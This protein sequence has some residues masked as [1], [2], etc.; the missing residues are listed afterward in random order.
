MKQLPEDV[1]DFIKK[2]IEEFKLDIPR[3]YLF[4]PAKAINDDS[5]IYNIFIN[6]DE[7][8]TSYEELEQKLEELTRLCFIKFSMNN[9]AEYG[10]CV[11]SVTTSEELSNNVLI[12]DIIE[13]NKKE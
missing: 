3:L 13:L 11:Y 9:A 7:S 8:E 5:S 1:F 10:C 6:A 12:T 2:F 4:F